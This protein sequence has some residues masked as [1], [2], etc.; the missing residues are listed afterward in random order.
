MNINFYEK[1]ENVKWFADKLI[2]PT[3]D[4]TETERLD[5]QSNLWF[6][7]CVLNYKL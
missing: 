7:T 1:H 4:S 3:K 5:N 6:V 2:E